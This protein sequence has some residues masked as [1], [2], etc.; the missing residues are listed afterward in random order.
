MTPPPLVVYVLEI[1][2]FIFLIFS[3]KGF[4]SYFSWKNNKMQL[5]INNYNQISP[6]NKTNIHQTEILKFAH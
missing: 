6:K 4:Y 1:W 2:I 5:V 3:S